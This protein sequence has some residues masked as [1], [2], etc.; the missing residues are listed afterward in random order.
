MK[1]IA[2]VW[3]KSTYHR[4]H[5]PLTLVLTVAATAGWKSRRWLVVHSAV[6]LCVTVSQSNWAVI[7]LLFFCCGFV[8]LLLFVLLWCCCF[9]RQGERLRVGHWPIN[10]QGQTEVIVC[11]RQLKRNK[12]R[13]GNT[14]NILPLSPPKREEKKKKKKRERERANNKNLKAAKMV[15]PLHKFIWI[16]QVQY[17]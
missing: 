4:L 5:K 10:R 3:S 12:V 17:L 11:C 15:I 1:S 6:L 13:E 8:C 14:W 16:F 2:F 9:L 7:G